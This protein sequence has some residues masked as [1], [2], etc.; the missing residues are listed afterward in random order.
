LGFL[1]GLLF[2]TAIQADTAP[3]AIAFNC[4]NCHTATTPVNL[5]PALD[6][7]SPQQIRELLLDFKYDKK[8]ATIMLRIAKGYSDA[9][10]TAV[11]DL[12]GRH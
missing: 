11:A 1:A 6:Q 10:L 3:Q 12:L 8:P 5:V 9:E 7:L 2:T 4:R